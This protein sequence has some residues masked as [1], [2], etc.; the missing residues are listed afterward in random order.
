MKLKKVI[1][2]IVTL[3]VVFGAVGGGIYGYK[4]Y[5]NKNLVAEVQPVSNINWG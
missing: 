5:Q 2:V 3:A 4:Y 1:A